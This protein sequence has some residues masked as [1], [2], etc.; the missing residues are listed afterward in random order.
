[1]ATTRK[2]KPKTETEPKP[3]PLSLTVELEEAAQLAGMS[4][5]ELTRTRQ[6]GIR[7]GRLGFKKDGVLVWNRS[8]FDG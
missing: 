3:K 1:M 5:D 7:P 2:P 6:R 4:P 8:D